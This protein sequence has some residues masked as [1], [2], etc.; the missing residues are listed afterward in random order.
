MKIRRLAATALFLLVVWPAIAQDSWTTKATSTV[1]F[2]FIV[3]GT[4]LPAGDYRIMTYLGNS[5]SIQNL[6]NPEYKAFVQ[7]T[8]VVLNP[9]RTIQKDTK[10]IF[11]LSNGQHVL[12]RVAIADDNHVHDITHASDVVELVATR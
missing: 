9:D 1:P 2:D 6:N 10:L 4:T 11:L 5:L 12:H 8:N 3:N 7:N